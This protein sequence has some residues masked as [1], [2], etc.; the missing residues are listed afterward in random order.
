MTLKRR[1]RRSSKRRSKSRS[2]PVYKSRRV[3]SRSRS[4]KSRR[5]S[6]RRS[7]R[8]IIR[9]YSQHLYPADQICTCTCYPPSVMGALNMPTLNISNVIEKKAAVANVAIQTEQ[10]LNKAVAAEQ[11]AK[12]N[13]IATQ[14]S[15]TANKAAIEKLKA[16]QE[17]V[18]ETKKLSE[19]ANE[20]KKRANVATTATELDAAAN[21][22]KNVVAVGNILEP[23][24][25]AVT[26]PDFGSLVIPPAPDIDDFAPSSKPPVKPRP[27]PVPPSK[28]AADRPD[29]SSVFAAIGS[30]N[31]KLKKAAPKAAPV[32][33]PSEFQKFKLKKTAGPR[34]P[35]TFAAPS[36]L[37][38]ISSGVLCNTLDKKETCDAQLDTTG[39]RRCRYNQMLRKC[40]DLPEKYRLAATLGM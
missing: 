17:I 24:I 11:Q 1:S 7:R 20:A 14:T 10:L 36:L 22:A 37:P 27:I 19:A 26:P 30:G 2:K 23:A 16:T 39:R 5:R 38:G 8:R 4:R 34:P 15:P 35:P 6:I 21:K 13:V 40:E 31:V 3:K 9:R 32:F 25:Q 12:S 18:K 29:M 28:T 33:N